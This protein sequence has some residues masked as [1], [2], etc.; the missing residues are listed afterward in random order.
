MMGW[1][2]FLGMLVPVS[3]LIQVGEQAMADRYTYLPLIGPAIAL[4]WWL[5]EA[6]RPAWRN[7]IKLPHAAVIVIIAC[8]TGVLMGLT[9]HQLSFWKDTVALF[10]HAVEVTADNPSAQFAMG[11]GLEH[12]GDMRNAMVHY[13]VA[14]AID[15]K[16]RKAYYNMGQ[17][18]RKTGEFKAAAKA[19]SSALRLSPTDVPTL[20]NLASVL[21][22]LG[23]TQEAIAH[24]DQA[25]RLDPDSIEGL[26]NLAWLLST[27]ADASNR[28]GLRAVQ[29]AERACA[30]TQNQQP[31]LLGTL[32]AAYAESGRFTEAIETAQKASA[33]ATELG[34]SITATKNKEFIELY[35]TKSAYREKLD[36][37]IGKL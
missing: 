37:G 4:V 26:N 22:R 24:L 35:R 33:R 28:N 21:A 15:P 10:G 27:S 32:A 34:D 31:V 8:W 13:R 19:Y 17:I 2:W 14:L 12:Q 29:L 9:R 16:Y 1:L 3:G 6:T 30:L 11:V 36:A 20:L 23:Q 7:T 25:L 5:T 18:L